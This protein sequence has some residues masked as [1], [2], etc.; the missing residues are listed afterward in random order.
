MLGSGG[1]S[2]GAD[3][4]GSTGPT[5]MLGGGPGWFPGLPDL[6]GFLANVLILKDSR[7]F[8]GGGLTLF[9]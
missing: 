3:A 5:G 2:R 1:G 9:F 6:F 8:P 7:W 4:T